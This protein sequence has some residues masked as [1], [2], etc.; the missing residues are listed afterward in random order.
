VLKK[1]LEVRQKL[2]ELESTAQK[3]KG[4]EA[5]LERILENKEEF[6]KLRGELPAESSGSGEDKNQGSGAG[7]EQS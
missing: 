7:D 6:E 1:L 2:H 3:G 5:L 4:L